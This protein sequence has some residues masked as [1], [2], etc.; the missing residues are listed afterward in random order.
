VIFGGATA[1]TLIRFPLSYI[2]HGIPMGMRLP[3]PCGA[4]PRT[5]WSTS[6][7]GLPRWRETGTVGLEKEQ[8]EDPF[9]A[10]GMRFV[11]DGYDANFIRD[12]LERD[13]DNFLTHLDEG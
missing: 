13:R 10:T 6:S 8:I 1:A 7:R 5:N 4:R 2:F 11:A 12:N 3:S 9:L